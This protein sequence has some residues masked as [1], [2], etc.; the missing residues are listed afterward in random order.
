MDKLLLFSDVLSQ[1]PSFR[2]SFYIY[3]IDLN[4]NTLSK[5]REVFTFA[6]PKNSKDSEKQLPRHTLVALAFNPSTWEVE[7]GRS[8]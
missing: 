1:G 4:S 3:L 5:F 7:A 2:F 6:R 8:L